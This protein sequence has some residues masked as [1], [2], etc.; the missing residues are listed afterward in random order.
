M[1]NTLPPAAVFSD[2][3]TFYQRME[4]DTLV[5][6]I[7]MDNSYHIQLIALTTNEIK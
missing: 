6:G 5:N 1:Q 3:L 2:Y 7:R 4:R